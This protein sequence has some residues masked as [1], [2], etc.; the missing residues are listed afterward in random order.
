M[1]PISAFF[2]IL[3]TTC[4][5][6]MLVMR[7]CSCFIFWAFLS[8][9]S[10]TFDEIATRLPLVSG[11]ESVH[12]VNMPPKMSISPLATTTECNEVAGEDPCVTGG[13]FQ[14]HEKCERI[15]LQSKINV[16]IGNKPFRPGRWCP[17]SCCCSGDSTCP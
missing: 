3:G 4:S 9:Y 17:V 10:K 11:L 16:C 8:V 1:L 5:D 2:G 12:L 14:E 15:W 6:K 7:I 13:E